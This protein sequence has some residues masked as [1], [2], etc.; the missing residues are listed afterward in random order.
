MLDLLD[1][2]AAGWPYLFI[3]LTELIIVSYV[4]GIKNYLADLKHMVGF[5]P[6]NWLKYPFIFIYMVLSPLI[7]VVSKFQPTKF[8][9]FSRIALDYFVKLC[10]SFSRSSWASLGLLT[11]LSPAEAIYTQTGPTESGG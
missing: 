10:N 11:S 2:Y 8:S 3:G 5:D 4:Y 1:Y 6:Q 9:Y 7:I